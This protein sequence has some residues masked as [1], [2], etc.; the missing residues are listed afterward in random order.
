MESPYTSVPSMGGHN[1]Y[2]LKGVH[3]FA[4]SLTIDVLYIY[5]LTKSLNP[6]QSQLTILQNAIYNWHTLRHHFSD[7][8]T[9]TL[10]Q[11]GVSCSYV[12]YLIIAKYVPFQR[13]FYDNKKSLIFIAS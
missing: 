8:H 11:T 4:H 1:N 2:S 3:Q 5:A 10:S 6:F 13:H 12:L 7:L 9:E